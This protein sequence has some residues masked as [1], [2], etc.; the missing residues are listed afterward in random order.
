MSYYVQSILRSATG[1]PEDDQTNIFA[2][3]QIGVLD[4]AYANDWAGV[5]RAFYGTVKTAIGGMRGIAQD[6]HLLKFIEIG[7]PQPNYPKFEIT[8]NFLS[9]ATA[10]ELPME[11]A[12]CASYANSRANTV[13]RGRRRGRIYLSGWSEDANAAGRPGAGTVGA[14]A[15][16]YYD[17]VVAFNAIGTLDAGVWSRAG[18]T[19]YPIDTVHVDN[20]W[21]TQRRRGSKST[22]RTTITL[23]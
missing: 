7:L 5:I 23:P 10:I 21:D 11:V 3:G 18:G 19:V 17:Y 12:L 4:Q 2:A 1:N 8:W 13:P 9:A 6:N 15:Q 22:A 16:A 14:L 20:A